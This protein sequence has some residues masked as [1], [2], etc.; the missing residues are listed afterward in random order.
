MRGSRLIGPLRDIST[1]WPGLSNCPPA[2]TTLWPSFSPLSMTTVPESKA[3]TSTGVVAT[4]LVAGSTIQTAGLPS[5]EVSACQGSRTAFAGLAL[6][7]PMTAAPSGMPAGVSGMATLTRTEPEAWS[8]AGEISRTLPVALICG[9][10]NSVIVTARRGRRPGDQ[11]LLHVEHRVAVAVL[12]DGE[13]GLR[14]LHHL[15]GFDLAGGDD[16]GGAGLELGEGQVLLGIGERALRGI[17]AALRHL[18]RLVGG[19]V[20]A[21]G[22]EALGKQR[23]L[24]LEGGGGLGQLRLRRVKIGLRRAQIGFLLLRID[25]GKHR[26]LVDMLADIDKPLGDAAAD[27]ERQI[28]QRARR[29]HAGQR[30]SR[31]IVG[32]RHRF[33]AHHDRQ[34]PVRRLLLL[35]AGQHQCGCADEKRRSGWKR[36][37]AGGFDRWR[38]DGRCHVP[39]HGLPQPRALAD[40][41][42]S[43]ISGG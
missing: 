2:V 12:G 37:K 15:A 25:A 1:V 43:R 21:P 26:A 32:Q 34:F 9:S 35:A 8:T 4:A 14:G 20:V 19:V 18:Q 13:D 40:R 31:R 23:L 41:E 39:A 10:D 33:G 3:S 36:Q 42:A 6:T 17:D 38:R 27:P 5:L 22:G 11:R 29:D 30:G 28:V 24:P 7:E 16:A